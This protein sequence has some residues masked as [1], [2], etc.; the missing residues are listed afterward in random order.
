HQALI[1]CAAKKM[2]E[3]LFQASFRQMKNFVSI[4]MKSKKYFWMGDCGP[5]KFIN[6]MTQFNRVPFQKISPGGSIIEQ[7]FYA[8]AGTRRAGNRLLA[9]DFRTLDLNAG[10]K[11]VFMPPCT[12]FNLSDSGN[13]SHCLTAKAHRTDS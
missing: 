8:D 9:D 10:A 3:A 13:R 1:I 11:F 5:L 7:V 2:N 4:M 6:N 12:E